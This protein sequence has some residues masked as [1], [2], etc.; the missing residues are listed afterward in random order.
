MAASEPLPPGGV[1]LA[2][3]ARAAALVVALA[4]LAIA[5]RP[6]AHIF[7]MPLTE[8][9]YYSLSVAR[10][11][12][13]GRGLTIDG[14]TLT[15]GFQP[16]FTIFEGG[17]F[18]LAGGNETLALRFV[19]AFAWAFHAIGAVLVALIA[20]D[21]WPVRHGD[22]ERSLRAALAAF[23]Y[24]A[25]PLLLN[26]AYN[27]LETGCVMA[28][29]AACWRLMQ[30][31]RDESWF[32]L[33]LFGAL[34]GLMVLAR[35]DSAF[36]AL[37]LGLNEM[38]RSWS[39]G[40][41]TM[42]AR[43]AVMGGT[44]L[45]VSSPWWI[46]N[47]LYFG[48]P[49]PTS[50]TAQQAWALEWLRLEFAEWA[51]RLVAVPWIFAGAYEGTGAVSI[52]WPFG[53]A[54]AMDLTP[55][56]TLRLLVLVAVVVWL[57]RAVRRR[58]FHDTPTSPREAEM[59]RRSF[60]FAACF[61]L[62][63]AALVVY[64]ALSFTAYWFFYRYFAPAALFAF[65]IAPVLWARL[66]TGP[67]TR[68]CRLASVALVAVLAAQI[69]SLAILA[70]SGRGI[71]GNTV[72]HDQIALVRQHVPDSEPVAAGQTGTLGY[73]RDRV[74]NLDGKVNVEAL[75]YQSH[76]WDYLRERNIK[77]FVDWPHYA[78]KYLGVPIGEGDVPAAEHN[79]WRRVAERNYFYLY[80]YVGE[81]K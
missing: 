78:N 76:M 80:E 10:N 75:K 41:V 52:P 9:G 16:L 29:Y 35:I 66:A 69:V 4:L 21:I 46:Y 59:I 8:D 49:M 48:S 33:A 22:R 26:H 27:G 28:F 55:I 40:P 11:L 36:L 32:G 57:V 79:G 47:T 15:N 70:Q 77:W 5:L 18:A 81:K 56:G 6:A 62:A 37:I 58:D 2:G 60:E 12:A 43:A 17:A 72:Y 63:L 1:R 19:L 20:R 25:A 39:R 65:V 7:D 14:T 3:L 34:I 61:A 53:P 74:V 45:L 24:L 68:A 23:L 42:L 71:G 64:Y 54:Q 30:T 13:A 31:G 50:G 51:L 67:T 38:R 44:A 73:F